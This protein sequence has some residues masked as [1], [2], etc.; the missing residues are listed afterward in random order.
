[1]LVT[2]EGPATLSREQLVDIVYVWCT[3]NQRRSQLP[4]PVEPTT[5]VRK[6]DDLPLLYHAIIILPCLAFSNPRFE[7]LPHEGFQTFCTLT[8]S[9]PGVSYSD[10]NPNSNPNPTPNFNSDI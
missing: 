6:S 9:Y 8:F 1:M 10:P 2:H 7:S 4:D 5:L 3:K